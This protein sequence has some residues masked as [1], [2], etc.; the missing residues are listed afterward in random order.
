MN[1]PSETYVPT[2]GPNLHQEGRAPTK[3]N[4]RAT[5]GKLQ[6]GCNF[7]T[8]SHLGEVAPDSKLARNRVCLNFD[9]ELSLTCHTSDTLLVGC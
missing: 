1:P 7:I 5:L 6:R 3:C 2:A 9:V 4:S 8:D